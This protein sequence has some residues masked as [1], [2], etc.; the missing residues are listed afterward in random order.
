MKTK[1]IETIKGSHLMENEVK[2][3]GCNIPTL[4]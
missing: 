1:N 2:K 3:E 4:N